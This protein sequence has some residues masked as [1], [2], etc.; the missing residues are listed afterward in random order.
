MTSWKVYILRLSNGAFY[1]GIT[2]NIEDRM[3]AHK[4]SKGSK[5]V[6]AHL[7]FELVWVQETTNRSIASKIEAKIKKLSHNSKEALV[8][9]ARNGFSD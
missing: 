4:N 5:Y 3:K 1:T 9:G 7:P 6:R 8:K 2:N